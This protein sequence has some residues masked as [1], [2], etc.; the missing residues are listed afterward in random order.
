[1]ARLKRALSCSRAC[2]SG[3]AH[4]LGVPGLASPAGWGLK[5]QK[6]FSQFWRPEVWRSVSSGLTS[7]ESS[8]WLVDSHLLPASSRGVGQGAKPQEEWGSRVGRSLATW[9]GGDS[10][11]SQHFRSSQ[12]GVPDNCQWWREVQDR[13]L[14]KGER[15]GTRAPNSQGRGWAKV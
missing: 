6:A 3:W 2:H 9:V 15:A 11:W 13:G 5:P 14:R 10:S 1:M 12:P 7:S 8:L 4:L